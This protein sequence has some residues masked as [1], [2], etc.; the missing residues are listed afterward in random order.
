VLL[1]IWWIPFFAQ[2][3]VAISPKGTPGLAEMP[4]LAEVLPHQIANAHTLFNVAL[5]ITMLPFTKPF[6]R[7]CDRMLPYEMAPVNEVF[8]LKFL[9][10]RNMP[11]PALALNLAKREVIRKV[12][13][14]IQK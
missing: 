10:E 12:K 3:V 9:D 8:K 11:T 4:H 6:A 1:F 14:Q 2:I 5:T 13:N 7:F